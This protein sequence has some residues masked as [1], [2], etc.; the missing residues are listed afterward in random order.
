MNEMWMK[1]PMNMPCK[2]SETDFMA[3]DIIVNNRMCKKNGFVYSFL[4]VKCFSV[5]ILNQDKKN[6]TKECQIQ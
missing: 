3:D 6:P 5:N 4:P 1:S 2:Q